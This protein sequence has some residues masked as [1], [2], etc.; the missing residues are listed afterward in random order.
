MWQY[1]FHVSDAGISILIVFLHHF[2]SLLSSLVQCEF[3][4]H[5]S[6]ACPTS[7]YNT[8]KIFN[9]HVDQFQQF[10]VCPK[11]NS[12]YTFDQCIEQSAS[13]QKHCKK[14]WYISFPNHTRMQQRTQCGG[15]LLNTVQLQS[16]ST[17]FRPIKV[18]C[19]QSLRRSIA[20]LFQ[21]EHFLKAIQLWRKRHVPDNIMGDVYDGNIWQTFTDN[22]G[23]CFVDDPC[24]LMVF[25]NVDW[26]QPFTHVT[27]S[28]GAMYL[29]I[30]NLPRSERYKLENVIL[31]GIIPGPKEPKHTINQYLSHLVKEL[32][33]FW[34]GV[35]ILLHN[36]RSVVV[37][38]ALTGISCDLPAVRKVCGFSGFSA[39]LGC[40][41]CL[42]KFQSRSFGQ[43]LDY[44][45]Y[46]KQHWP[47]RTLSTHKKAATQYS[48][49]KTPAEQ[50]RI[51]SKF[52]VRYSSLLDLPYF[53]PIRFHV[54]DPMHNLLL[55]T[56]RHMMQVWTK[57]GILSYQNF[58]T[59]ED[60]V[61]AITT[62]KDIGRL[63]QKISSSFSGFTA[64][65]WK[66]WTT[67]F[68]VVCLKGILP[69]DHLNCWI[70]F[71]KACNLL[72]T[73]VIHKNALEPADQFLQLFC[74]SF[75]EKKSAHPICI[76][77]Y[78]SKNLLKT[79]GQFMDFG[80]LRSKDLMVCWVPIKPT[81]S[82][83]SLK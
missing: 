33:D 43:K 13:G 34:N 24:N 20:L 70:L 40:S 61:R 18:F 44:S 71:A 7:L 63:P 59:I 21:Q 5:I 72:C 46:N 76:C 35:E 58:V 37:K 73:R 8:R 51:L 77:I 54:I 23:K 4:N 82:I 22:N 3:L 45:G 1:I 11:C 12:V 15:P 68:S 64:D 67:I 9:L 29:S 39:I 66:N 16:G 78:T 26:F 31:I 42:H 30:Q 53:D 65:Q 56:A 10:V 57:H 75:M 79:M 47:A 83:L 74:K 60:R 50:K 38:L 25:L 69:Q 41:K 81:T 80:V 19:Y 14:C 2:L 32:K 6:A 27:D 48:M 49:A 52:G 17:Y 36:G 28:V 62:P 55:G